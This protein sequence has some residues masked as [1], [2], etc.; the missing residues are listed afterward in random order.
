VAQNAQVAS[1]VRI[2]M[3]M[4]LTSACRSQ[5]Q[6]ANTM[7]RLP[8]KNQA[9][10][11]P[12]TMSPQSQN[13]TAKASSQ[14]NNH[15]GTASVLPENSSAASTPPAKSEVGHKP[16]RKPIANTPQVKSKTGQKF[17]HVPAVSPQAKLLPGSESLPTVEAV[18]AHYKSHIANENRQAAPPNAP[19]TN[20]GTMSYQRTWP[21]GNLFSKDNPFQDKAPTKLFS[22]PQGTST[23][24]VM[25]VLEDA[26]KR[27]G[28][29]FDP[30][31]I[32]LHR[33]PEAA[34]QLLLS[35]PSLSAQ[36]KKFADEMSFLNTPPT[37]SCCK[38][39]S[40][41][42]DIP[43]NPLSSVGAPASSAVLQ[44][45]TAIPAPGV[46][47]LGVG[48][49]P[50]TA[51]APP[52]SGKIN[53]VETST[54]MSYHPSPSFDE[55]TRV[56]RMIESDIDRMK[57]QVDVLYYRYHRCSRNIMDLKIIPQ[58][59]PRD[60]RLYSFVESRLRKYVAWLEVLY[61]Q[62]YVDN[63]KRSLSKGSIVE[64]WA[65]NTSE[66]DGAI[67]EEIWNGNP[68]N[69]ARA[70][71]P[72][73]CDVVDFEAMYRSNSDAAT[74]WQEYNKAVYCITCNE[75]FKTYLKNKDERFH[76]RR[77]RALPT[78]EDF[79]RHFKLGTS[80]DVPVQK[81]AA[82]K[83]NSKPSSALEKWFPRFP[84]CERPGGM[85]NGNGR[86]NGDSG[87]DG[88]ASTTEGAIATA[89]GM[90]TPKK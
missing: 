90:D 52:T 46:S 27:A 59:I 53:E 88:N 70:T 80:N 8:R 73:I 28:A 21:T 72:M 13:R 69:M 37:C 9:K 71:H 77:W 51:G 30:S 47:A 2:G 67:F 22:V 41:G 40:Y 55:K 45:S 35:N 15:P 31:R 1:D 26:A 38:N 84:T 10:L 18:V 54:G 16:L 23:A 74:Q 42:Y 87:E 20:S 25:A 7:P 49:H 3:E 75:I 61:I 4:V 12:D 29:P 36:F 32:D 44:S 89:G 43:G 5:P 63:V 48:K 64:D 79:N 24:E 76:A 81:R 39:E 85:I 50:N 60:T 6:P 58:I 82:K 62:M 19:Q 11:H 56:W 66:A 65:E 34:A 33:L 68:L 86:E 14:A 57:I 17:L 83:M 78:S